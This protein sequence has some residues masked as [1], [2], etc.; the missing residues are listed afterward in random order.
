MTTNAHDLL[1]AI[2]EHESDWTISWLIAHADP[3]LWAPR[4]FIIVDELTKGSPSLA[5]TWRA[6]YRLW[7]FYRPSGRFRFGLRMIA[8]VGG[9]GRGHLS[10]IYGTIRKLAELGLIIV[11]GMDANPRNDAARSDRW[12]YQIDPTRLEARSI[13]FI[14]ARLTTGHRVARRRPNAQQRDLFAALDLAPAEAI[15]DLAGADDAA[16]PFIEIPRVAP[17]GASVA[18]YRH[19][20]VP[21]AAPAPVGASGQGGLAPVG[22]NGQGGLAPV[23]GG[24]APVGANSQ[25]ELAPT[26]AT[27]TSVDTAGA[28]IWHPEEPAAPDGATGNAHMAPMGATQHPLVPD[29][30]P[31]GATFLPA[32]SEGWRDGSIERKRE[33]ASD[34]HAPLTSLP[35]IEQLI[36]NVLARQLAHLTA[37][38][39]PQAVPSPPDDSLM[40][41]LIPHTVPDTPPGEPTLFLP[42][43]TI[44]EK[45]N[46]LDSVSHHDLIQ[47]KMLIER[48]R[49]I[50]DGY[51]TYWLGRVMLFADMCRSD[52]E[53][54]KFKL[55]NSYM[56]RMKDVGYSTD[57][58]ED[59]TIK[60][61]KGATESGHTERRSRPAASNQSAPAE[62]ITHPAIAAYIAAFGK[63]PNDVQITQMVET[64]TDA[65]AWQRVLTD[66]QANGW[67]ANGVAKMLDRY[68]KETGTPPADEQQP[69]SISEIYTY[70]DLEDAVRDR[71]VHLYH[72]ATSPAEK[73]A[74]I[75]RMQ[76]EHPYE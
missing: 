55:I 47:I 17:V 10:G 9:V 24:L 3:E 25:L 73:R 41:D 62:S 43:M 34:T 33:S 39:P 68:R 64:V 1:D 16:P 28:R 22:A 69:V 7:I 58:L 14:R 13:Q 5:A 40:R 66:W 35:A 75:T 21:S 42:L 53:P 54:I 70:P 63:T 45:I 48:Y 19:S 18:A 50:T 26:G 30:A 76:K 60:G 51:S 36:E 11:T 27:F 4:Q 46:H 59:R 15:L 74:V 2:Q 12:E 38:P 23:Q 31:M 20:P 6:I 44:W 67:Q 61:E 49:K 32:D 8:D 57:T 37:A 71:W 65:A 72:A 56:H 52:Q 29:A